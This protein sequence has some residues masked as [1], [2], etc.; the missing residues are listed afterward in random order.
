MGGRGEAR[1]RRLVKSEALANEASADRLN[2]AMIV[3]IGIEE[4]D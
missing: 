3:P 4:K 2:V 1:T